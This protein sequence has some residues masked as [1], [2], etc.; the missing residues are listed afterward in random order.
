MLLQKTLKSVQ[1]H[2]HSLAHALDQRE[3]TAHTAVTAGAWT[4]ARAKL[5]HSAFIELNEAIETL[6]SNPTGNQ[7]RMEDLTSHHK[8]VLRR[9]WRR[10]H[11]A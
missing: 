9:Q 5:K 8:R 1:L 2:I 11:E 10:W 4:R 3:G 7:S 6:K